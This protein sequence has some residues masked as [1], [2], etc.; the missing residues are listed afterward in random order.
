MFAG[1][2]FSAANH[3]YNA[4]F[5]LW[6]SQILSKTL[7]K[8]HQLHITVYTYYREYWL[9]NSKLGP[10]CFSLKSL[11]LQEINFR[12][13]KGTVSRDFYQRHCPPVLTTPVANCHRFQWHRRQICHRC[14]RHRWQTMG[15]ILDC[16]QLKVNLK[17]KIYLYA[18][19]TTQRCPKE[20]MK[21]FLIEDFFQLPLVSVS[22][23]G[24]NDTGVNDTG[25]DETG[26]VHL[27]LQIS[28]QIFEKIWNGSN[29]I[30]RG[31]GETDPCRKPEVENLVALSL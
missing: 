6:C 16:W 14:Q 26:V 2:F 18:N 5:F 10:L 1:R 22:D 15:T 28:P 20:V 11:G 13:M 9:L 29:G 21:T 7:C 27:E 30:I 8:T 25:V 24:V 12:G 31:L 3:A 19:S 17:E 4:F 23:T